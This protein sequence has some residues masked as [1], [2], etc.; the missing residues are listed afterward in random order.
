MPK[1]ETHSLIE[2]LA[3]REEERMKA[4]REGTPGVQKRLKEMI[5]HRWG[6]ILAIKQTEIPPEIHE[7]VGYKMPKTSATV[8]WMSP[9]PSD[10]D[11]FGKTDID[12]VSLFT[13]LAQNTLWEADKKNEV[14]NY[15]QKL[16]DN[17]SEL[18]HKFKI[19]TEIRYFSPRLNESVLQ[20]LWRLPSPWLWGFDER[21]EVLDVR[22]SPSG[23]WK[24]NDRQQVINYMRVV[25]DNIE[26]IH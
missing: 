26:Y 11:V 8:L 22:R 15:F 21:D 12:S 23:M 24:D 14:I 5:L 2:Y 6:E 18:K 17:L 16:A 20:T 1:K 13:Q 7:I 3:I 10:F 4:V 19:P 25:A 9:S